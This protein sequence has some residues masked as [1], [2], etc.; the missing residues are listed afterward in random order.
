MMTC[1]PLDGGVRQLNPST[2]FDTRGSSSF[3]MLWEDGERV[4]YGGVS[5]DDVDGP[6]V[7]AVMPAAEHPKP[8]TL[9]RLAHEYGLK[10]ELDR[11][12]A[13]RPLELIRERGWTML[14]LEDPG[15]E[16]LERLLGAP[17][18]TDHFLRL[19]IDITVAIGRLYPRGRPPKAR[20]PANLTGDCARRAV[21]FT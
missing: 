17:L 14:V 10:D 18:E 8:A 7:L 16:P 19:A 1:D 9:D 15:G 13:A 21:R 5:R 4:F 3:Q 2:L 20:K 6:T 11:A 12:W